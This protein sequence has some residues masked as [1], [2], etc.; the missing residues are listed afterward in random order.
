MIFALCIL[1]RTMIF[2]TFLIHQNNRGKMLVLGSTHMFADPYI[3]REENSLLFDVLW[4]W[5]TGGDK[6]LLNSIDADDPDISDYQCAPDTA[7]NAELLRTC[8]Q[9]K[10]L[11]FWYIFCFTER[12]KEKGLV[13]IIS[14]TK[15]FNYSIFN[16]SN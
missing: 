2:E 6:V 12:F 14:S 16:S 15:V 3:D 11:F 7:R 1:T 9:V 8:L 10:N 13:F 5:L 4:S